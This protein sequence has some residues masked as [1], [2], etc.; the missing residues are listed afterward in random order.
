MVTESA[1]GLVHG[2]EMVAQVAATHSIN[3][4]KTA[5]SHINCSSQFDVIY[6]VSKLNGISNKIHDMH[7]TDAT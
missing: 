4:F 3:L 1:A 2:I 7:S 5:F 6:I